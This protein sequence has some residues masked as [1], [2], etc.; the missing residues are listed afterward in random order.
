MKVSKWVRFSFLVMTALT[1]C[2]VPRSDTNNTQTASSRTC[3]QVVLIRGLWNIYSLGLNDLND[4]LVAKGYES[5]V[6]SGPDWP[7]AADALTRRFAG[8]KRPEKIV[9]IG[10]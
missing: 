5:E 9:L 3:V 10:H 1:G 4:Q 7:N 6:I 2:M 8:H